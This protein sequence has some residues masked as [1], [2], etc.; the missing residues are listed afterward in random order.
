M[1]DSL[2]LGAE[3]NCHVLCRDLKDNVVLFHRGDQLHCRSEDAMEVDGA[4]YDSESPL[5]RSAQI[6]AEEFSM[7]LED[8]GE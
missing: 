1:A 8:L 4:S 6:T 7:S 3:S 2:I 5:P